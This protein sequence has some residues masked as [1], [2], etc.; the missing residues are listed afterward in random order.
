MKKLL[1]L[2]LVLLVSGCALAEIEAPALVNPHLAEGYVITEFNDEQNE[3]SYLT[4]DGCNDEL[5]IIEEYGSLTAVS[6]FI[7][8]GE[9]TRTERSTMIPSPYGRMLIMQAQPNGMDM[10][11]YAAGDV[12]VV[13]IN[14]IWTHT[15]N[16]FST[17]DIDYMWENYR[18]PF[19]PFLSFLGMRETPGGMLHMLALSSEGRIYEYVTSG[20][21]AGMEILE[22]R[23]YSLDEDENYVYDLRVTFE[24]GKAEI[25][26]EALRMLGEFLPITA[27]SVLTSG[28]V[29]LREGPGLDYPSICAIPKGAH[30]EY[31]DASE[32]DE[33][34][35][36]W[37]NVS[38]NGSEGW[39]SGKYASPR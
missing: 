21:T 24:F 17:E 22:I 10:E 13:C 4:L 12:S 32:L 20:L 23:R 33:R 28:N 15:E 25:P 37:Y 6:E 11:I 9:V 3:I 16:G 7:Q 39:I 2:L 26:D 27:E 19:C 5:A 29:N 18:F 38:Y 31:L 8:D 34:G 36:I 14:G 35:Q 30:T 1:A